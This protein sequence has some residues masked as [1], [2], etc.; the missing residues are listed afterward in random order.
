MSG[1]DDADRNKGF[2][3]RWSQRKQEAKQPEPKQDAPAAAA[4]VVPAEPPAEAEEAL[5]DDEAVAR[6]IASTPHFSHDRL[7]RRLHQELS[8]CVGQCASGRTVRDSGT[9]QSW[10]TWCGFRRFADNRRL[11]LRVTAMS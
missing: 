11:C 10:P 6:W 2:L 8:R 3:A 5:D 1:P 4:P 7:R 9:G